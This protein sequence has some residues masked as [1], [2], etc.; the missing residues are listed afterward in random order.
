MKRTTQTTLDGAPVKKRPRVEPRKVIVIDG[1]ALVEKVPRSIADVLVPKLTRAEIK[2]L[3]ESRSLNTN[4]KN[5][6]PYDA[7]VKTI[8]TKTQ[9]DYIVDGELTTTKNG[10][11][12]VSAWYSMFWKP[13]DQEFMSKRSAASRIRKA[14]A[15]LHPERTTEEDKLAKE[16][17][18][19][20]DEWAYKRDNGSYRHNSYDAFLQGYVMS[21]EEQDAIPTGF[22]KFL[23]D[24]PH[25]K[26]YRTEWSFISREHKLKGQADGVFEDVTTDE[27][28]LVDWK[29][30][31]LKAFEDLTKVK[32]AHGYHILT[33]DTEHSSLNV[34]KMQLSMYHAMLSRWYLQ[35]TGRKLKQE[36]LL[37]NFNPANVEG[38]EVYAFDA[39][40][41]TPYLELMPWNASDPRHN[42]LSWA[43][44]W[45]QSKLLIPLL[46]FVPLPKSPEDEEVVVES[47]EI[48]T[49]YHRYVMGTT[50]PTGFIW[51]G[52]DYP[53]KKAREENP[54][55]PFM[56]ASQWRHPIFWVGKPPISQYAIYERHLLSSEVLLSQVHTLYGKTLV[57][58][59]YDDDPY[60]YARV[61]MKYADHSKGRPLIS[62]RIEPLPFHVSKKDIR[63]LS[64]HTK[65][66]DMPRLLP[67]R[68]DPDL[69]SP[70]CTTCSL[71][72]PRAACIPCG[73]VYSCVQCVIDAPPTSC[74]VCR[75]DI[76]S[77][78][79]WDPL[80]SLL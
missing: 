38:Y 27:L 10:W 22:Y 66:K 54:K 25:L 79:R 17:K 58:W 23:L 48:C 41:M 13:F 35:H 21:E 1:D 50:L 71:R 36:I 64:T 11:Y 78:V 51:I 57:G 28:Q 20:L 60:N 14:G 32:E 9:H 39:M 67:P 52:Y 59:G 68:T 77:V 73:H 24:Y 62:L 46:P 3:R 53:G 56:P 30:C 26:T 65:K 15:L 7:A 42:D 63:A 76:M 72:P 43:M 44:Q 45:V 29:N 2:A 8:F 34:Y 49:S 40:D 47:S 74:N 80:T 4:V 37:L 61:L 33:Y 5:K 12:S 31:T 6:H 75:T 69:P 19:V 70:L 16:T 55:L 18:I